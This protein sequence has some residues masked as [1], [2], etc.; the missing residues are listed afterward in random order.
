MEKN[1]N[2]VIIK[3]FSHHHHYDYVDDSLYSLSFTQFLFKLNSVDSFIHSIGSVI[4][5]VSL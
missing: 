4:L 5:N 2:K 1:Y 3:I